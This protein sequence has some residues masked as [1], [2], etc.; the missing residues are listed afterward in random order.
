ME[1]EKEYFPIFMLK[2]ELL[3]KIDLTDE[4]PFKIFCTWRFNNSIRRTEIFKRNLT[5]YRN[6]IIESFNFPE[7]DEASE[8]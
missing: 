2:Q 3:E 7:L 1:V 6:N 4:N 8:K 5:K